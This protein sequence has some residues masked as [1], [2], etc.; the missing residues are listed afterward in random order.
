VK[1]SIWQ[2]IKDFFKPAPMH[3]PPLMYM[4]PFPW[5][6]YAF[7]FGMM[8]P[9]LGM[10][11]MMGNPILNMGYAAGLSSVMAQSAA[12]MY[13]HIAPYGTISPYPMSYFMPM[14]S[15]PFYF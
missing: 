11:P 13:S 12:S 15:S 1:K 7:P 6:M 2:K 10:G 3:F 4:N 8:N 9:M 14:G 5:G